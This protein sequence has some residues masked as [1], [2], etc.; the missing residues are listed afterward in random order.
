VTAVADSSPDLGVRGSTLPRIWTPPLV[1]LTPKTS[2]GFA[3]CEFARRIQRPLD[4]WQEWLAIHAGE[5]LPD[6]RP[7][8]RI[9]LVLVSRRTER[10]NCS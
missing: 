5:L 2:Y 7:P 6:G 4:P 8:F 9:V 10:R 3:A 1:D